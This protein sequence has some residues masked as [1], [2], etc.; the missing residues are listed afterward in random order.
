ML[1]LSV[2]VFILFL[3]VLGLF[4]CMGFSLVAS[5]GYSLVASRG[6]SLVASGGYSLVARRGYSLV[7]S[8]GYSVDAVHRL[9]TEAA[10]L[11]AER[12]L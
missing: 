8:G 6:Y 9:F 3:A 4:C 5:G 7:A 11:V 1:T 12:R 2:A 10:S